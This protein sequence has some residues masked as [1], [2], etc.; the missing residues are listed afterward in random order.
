VDHITIGLTDRLAF[1]LVL[2]AISNPGPANVERAGGAALCGLAPIIPDQIVYS[3]AVQ[4][5]IGI[6]QK[7]FESQGGGFPP[8][9]HIVTEEPPLK[10]YA[11]G[12]P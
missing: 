7:N 1:D 6:M 2:D 8:D 4:A 3:G 9:L 12:S 10:A 5:M 11:Q